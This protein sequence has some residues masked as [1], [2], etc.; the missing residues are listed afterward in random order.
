MRLV[1]LDDIRAAAANIAGAVIRTPLLSTPS[2]PGFF[3]KPESLQPIGAFKVRGAVHAV[4]S[5]AG[6]GPGGRRDHRTRPA[7]TGRRWPTRPAGSGSPC[8][9]VMPDVAAAVKIDAVRA[10]G[11]EVELVPPA[12][13][14]RPAR[15][16]RGRARG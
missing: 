4:A 8:V 13:R 14:L 2:W 1:S 9:V 3:V 10:L 15:G 11:A 12:E 6:R 5:L 7:T 16:A